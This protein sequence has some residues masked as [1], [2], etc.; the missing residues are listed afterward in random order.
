MLG[1]GLGTRLGTR[2]G[3]GLGTIAQVPRYILPVD[4][5]SCLLFILKVIGTEVH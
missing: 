3:T 2:L 4:G 5:T 1:T